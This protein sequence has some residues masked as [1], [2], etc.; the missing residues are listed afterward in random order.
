MKKLALIII[1]GIS[2]ATAH[3]QFQFGAKAGV[4]L[5]NLSDAQGY[6]ARTQASFNLGVFFKMPVARGLAVQPELYYSGQGD[7]FLDGTGG[8]GA[9]HINYFNVPILLKFAHHSG[10]YVETGP[11]FGFLVS[12]KTTYQDVTTDIKDQINSTDFA[13]VF[14]F[15]YKIPMSPVGIDFRYNAG[16]SNIA[17]DNGPSVHNNVFQFGLTYVLFSSGRK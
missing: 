6:S 16:L 13:W 14:G 12:A 4:N 7:K 5:T 3:A 2:F 9:D 17:N 11:Q 8:S 1:A 15:G 10:F